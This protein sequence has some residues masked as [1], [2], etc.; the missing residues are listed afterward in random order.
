MT[1]VVNVHTCPAG[2]DDLIY[3]LVLVLDRQLVQIR[4]DVISRSRVEVPV[5]ADTIAMSGRSSSLGVGGVAFIEAVPAIQGNMPYFA[6][7]LTDL[8]SAPGLWLSIREGND[9]QLMYVNLIWPKF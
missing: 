3:A 1:N 4:H 5:D 7:D 6:T 2:C 8:V 9:T